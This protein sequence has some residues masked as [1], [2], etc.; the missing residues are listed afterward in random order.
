VFISHG[1]KAVEHVEVDK[2]R[3]ADTGHD[4]EPASIKPL[5]ATQNNTQ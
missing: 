3:T 4:W 1:F 2:V 5:P